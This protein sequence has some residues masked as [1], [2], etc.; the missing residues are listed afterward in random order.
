MKRNKYLH[1]KGKGIESRLLFLVYQEWMASGQLLQVSSHWE[2]LE[3][4]MF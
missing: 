3:G 2:I 4:P 1:F